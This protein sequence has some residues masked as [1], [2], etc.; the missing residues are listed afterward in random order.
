MLRMPQEFEVH[1]TSSLQSTDPI[2]FQS[3]SSIDGT[4]SYTFTKPGTYYYSTDLT[5]TVCSYC[6]V[7]GT[8]T[9]KPLEEL[10]TTLK[11]SVNGFPSLYNLNDS[12][13]SSVET[14]ESGSGKDE[15]CL[16]W[17]DA[18]INES[19][20][21]PPLFVYSEC[22]TP[23]VHSIMSENLTLLSEYTIYGASFGDESENTQVSFWGVSC[24]PSSVTY[25]SIT[26]K[27]N[28][29]SFPL[30][31]EPLPL[32]IHIDNLGYGLLLGD[33][34]YDRSISLNPVITN[35]Q[36]SQGSLLGGNVLTIHGRSFIEEN[37]QVHIGN[38]ECSVIEVFYEWITC[39]IP[40]LAQD[41]SVQNASLSVRVAYNSSAN[42]SA[43]CYN[44]ANCSYTYTIDYTP[45]VFSVTPTEVV[46]EES[47]IITISGALLEE[48]SKVMVGSRHECVNVTKLDDENVTCILYPIPAAE[49][50]LSVLVAEYG[51]AEVDDAVIV[52]RLQV[53]SVS[54]MQGSIRG[55]TIIT[56][57]GSG[58]S[59]VLTENRVRMGE[60]MCEVIGSSYST[61]NCSTPDFGANGT[62]SMAI[63]VTV[64]GTNASVSKRQV[65]DFE[66]DGFDFDFSLESTP[67]I[68]SISPSSG[69]EGDSVTISGSSFINT[70]SDIIVTIGDSECSVTSSTETSITCT[71]GQNF[72]GAFPVK[73]T[74][75]GKG[76]A[77]GTVTF[78]YTLRVSGI[79]PTEGSFAGQNTLTVNGV[80][81]RPTSS[82]VTICDKQCTPS[83]TPPSLTSLSCI[84][85]SFAEI[86]SNDTNISS[87]N[88]TVVVSSMN[89]NV[90]LENAYTLKQELTSFVTSIND[91]RGGTA[92]GTIIKLGG[93]GF[94]GSPN[95]TVAG[96]KCTVIEYDDDEIICMTGAIG[97][98]LVAE[99]M[100]H[101][102]GKGYAIVSN[103]VYFYYVDL[104]SS[105]FTWGGERLPVEGDFVIVGAGQ[106]LVLD[107][108]TPILKILLIQ[109]GELIFDD[110]SSENGIQLHSELILITDGGSLKIGT[111]SHPYMNKAEIVMY[112]NVLSTELPLFGAK[113]LAVRNGTVDFHG[114]PITNTWTR[115]S[116]TAEPGVSTILVQDDV[117]DWEVDGKIVIASTS[118]SQ[119]ENEELTI[120]SIGPDG[121]TIHLK[122]PL[123][124][125][126]IFYEQTI[127]GRFIQTSAE[128]GY[129]TRNVVFRGNRNEE[130]DVEYEACE[131]EFDPG[132][133]AVQ[134][135]FNGRFGA[136]TVGDQFGGQLMLHKGPR[137]KVVGR[138]EYTEFTHVGQA[139]R[140]G[141]YPIHFHL[142]GDVSDSYV[143]GNAIHHTFN[144]AVTIHAVDYLLV[145]KN[146]AFDI[147]GH[148][149]FLE[150]GIEQGNIIQDNLGVFV[151]A[152]SS[153]L[154]VDI[155]PATFWVVN[156]NNTLRRN[157]AAGGSH[158]G[159]W[160]R[161]PANPTGPSFTTAVEPLHLPL[162]EFSDNTAHSFGWYGIWIFP[163]Y[164]PGGAHT[165]NERTPAVFKNFLS[166]RNVRGVEFSEVGAVQLVNSTMLDNEI[167]G[168]EYTTVTAAWGKQGALIEDT[169]IVAHS[170]LRD[171]DDKR[172]RGGG[173][174]CTGS[175]IKTPH[176]YYLTVSNVTF[177][178]FN[179]SNCF[180]LQACSHCR[181]QQGGFETRFENLTFTNSPNIATWKWEHEQVFR[182]MDGTLTGTVGGALLPWMNAL[183]QDSCQLHAAGSSGSVAGAI[184]DAS[185]Q[186]NRFAL[187]NPSP[188]SL[189]F[190]QLNATNIH[191]TVT[192]D[193]VLKRLTLGPGY[194][195]ILPNKLEYTLEWSEGERFTNISYSSLYSGVTGDDYLFIR[196][197]FPRDVDMIN[198]NGRTKNASIDK[199][200]P[201]VSTTGDWFSNSNDTSVTYFVGGTSNCPTNVPVQFTTYRCFYEDCIPPPPPEPSTPPPDGRPNVTYMWS[202]P[203]IWPNGVVPTINDTDITINSSFYVLVDE[204]DIIPRIR[205]L[206]IYGS[207]EILD[208]VDRVIQAELIIIDEFGQLIAGS[209]DEQYQHQLDFVLNGNLASPI[210]RL[211]NGGPVLGAKAIGVF[212]RLSLHAQE[213]EQTWTFLSSTALAG[214][215]EINVESPVDWR[216]GETIVIS[217]TSF[218]AN[219]AEEARVSSVSNDG[220]TITLDRPLA[221][222]HLGGQHNTDSCTVTISAEVGLL[223]RNIRVLGTLPDSTDSTADSEAYGCRVLVSTYISN[224][225]IQYAGSAQLSGVEFKG[226]GQ[227]GFVESFDPRYSLAFL[228]IGTVTGNSSYVTNCSVHDGYNVGIGVYG[229]NGISLMNNV[230]HNTVGTSIDVRG[231]GHSV[232][233]NLAVVAQFPGTYRG[234]DEPFNFEWTANYELTGA[235]D[236][237]L[238]GNSAAGGAR[239]G[240]HTNGENCLVEGFMPQWMNNIAH[241]TLMGI[242]LPY[243][244]GHVSGTTRG[245]SAL[246][247]FHI[248]SAYHY[249]I[250]SFSR[251]GIQISDCTLV[252]NYAAVFTAVIGPPALSHAISE[253]TVTISD[254][255]II[256]SIHNGDSVANCTAYSHKPVIAYH[257]RSHS[258]I[259]TL[260][261]GH[262]GIILT[263]FT[264][265]SGGFPK[266]PW[267]ALHNYPAIS[268]H[269]TLRN[270]TF[271]KFGMHCGSRREVAL[272]THPGSEDC[273][274]PVELHNTELIDVDPESKF[275]NHNPNLGSINPS[276]CVDMDC[277]GLKK[278]LIRD[279]DGSFIGSQNG[280]NT[281]TSNSALEWDGN[282]RRGLGD[283]RIPRTMLAEPDGGMIDPD[284]LYPNKGIYRGNNEC[285]FNSNWNSY[286]CTGID[287][288]MMVVESLDADTEVRRLSPIGI[289]AAGY[290]DLVNGPQDN[291]WCG[292]YTCQERISTFYTIVATG[293]EY[294]IGLASTNPQDMRLM[295]LNAESTQ[296]VLIGLFYN[297]PQRLDI[298]VDTRFIAPTNGYFDD[299]GNLRYSRGSTSMF[300]P[301]LSNS[302]GANFYDRTYKKLYFVIEGSKPITIMTQSVIQL[303]IDLPAVT[304]DEF[305]ETN[306]IQNLALLLNIPQNRIRIVNVVS[307]SSR[308]RQAS[309]TRVEIEIGSPPANET[310]QVNRTQTTGGNGTYYYN[311]TQTVATDEQFKELSEAATRTAEI[312]QTGALSDSI[313]V[314]ILSASLTP[315]EPEVVDPTGGV[316]ATEDTGGPQPGDPGTENRT[317]YSEQ[318]AQQ[319]EAVQNST[320]PISL[321]IPTALSSV[322]ISSTGIEGL[323][324]S[325]PIIIAMHDGNGDVVV[326]LGVGVAWR[327][328]VS[329][330][331]GPNGAF[332][333]NNSVDMENGRATFS[334]LMFSHAGSY[335]LRFSVSYPTDADFTLDAS[336]R[337]E[338]STRQLYIQIETQPPTEANTTF[339]LY[340][341]ARI[342]IRDRSNDQLALNLGW[343]ERE[344]SAVATVIES[345]TGRQYGSSHKSEIV[346]GYSMFTDIS[347]DKEGIYVLRFTL[348]TDPQSTEAELPVI[349]DSVEIDV[350][351][352]PFT[353]FEIV[354]NE[355]FE[356]VIGN[357]VE[358]FKEAF[359]RH[360]TQ[361][362]Q[363]ITIYNI[364][365]VS[366]SIIVSFFATT[367]NPDTLAEF[368]SAVTM[369]GLLDSFTYNGMTLNLTSAIQDPN[370]PIIYPTEPP[371]KDAK[372]FAVVIVSIAVGSAILLAMCV[373]TFGLFCYYG[374]RKV[375]KQNR[376][377]V[378]PIE[379]D[380]EQYHMST[381]YRNSPIFD[382]DGDYP[383][384]HI[385]K[386]DNNQLSL[387]KDVSQPASRSSTMESLDKAEKSYHEKAMHMSSKEIKVG[388]QVTVFDNPQMT[389]GDYEDKMSLDELIQLSSLNNNNNNSTMLSPPPVYSECHPNSVTGSEVSIPPSYRSSPVSNTYPLL[390][391]EP[392]HTVQAMPLGVA[393]N[394]LPPI[395]TPPK[396]NANLGT[397]LT[398]ETIH[399]LKVTTFN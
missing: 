214:A 82:F 319:Q 191:G 175:G 381:V 350:K 351:Q 45:M 166:W 37:L 307:E 154:N 170:E 259:Q 268:G 366:G 47:A 110:V 296:K 172:V 385:V 285:T 344:W 370:Y 7:A 20:T 96:I 180:A 48:D 143:R 65:E 334:D 13:L 103:D 145:E 185:V 210:Y 288:L 208:K 278:I 173:A 294:S 360:L 59:D 39:Q 1:Q 98:T 315:P 117:S 378:K 17:A 84:V 383:L 29:T 272:M 227:E 266:F 299:E 192:L 194:M 169:L 204:D 395:R 200:D 260:T 283:Y 51:Y 218:E 375:S 343:R 252:N 221:N 233:N 253:K 35:I 109:G 295:I 384:F 205:R 106:T 69:Q 165:C 207:L 58:F 293:L 9:V 316:R 322:A 105:I 146:V 330:I 245:C 130:W 331:S 64:A 255:R 362:H 256:S 349:V 10:V 129:L 352:L 18:A 81:F 168:V 6:T 337:I 238:Y 14:F 19:L 161:L 237:T 54:P 24:D 311:T 118:Y 380:Y 160:Y 12:S 289:G 203:S 323:T 43:V 342:S 189:T 186:F 270:V 123:A 136:E 211:P 150:D 93:T 376:L 346:D 280:L 139:F 250:F 107:T 257:P 148:A 140:L 229:T 141:R 371:K 67:M 279:L 231:S 5:N 177:V 138:I 137:D 243:P 147:K 133:F 32:S 332:L 392:A 298:F 314:M 217:S 230:V 53:N 183:P 265:G 126:H 359:V 195:A 132:Q 28:Q 264:S 27:L 327:L 57:S 55:G 3:Q 124:Y 113:T 52:S 40:K 34:I 78:S 382:E 86:I 305:F 225:G 60:Q 199:P 389:Q 347:I 94:N 263:S 277:D 72:V 171:Y 77:N 212:G 308:K 340:P 49:Y 31:F 101:I 387:A 328:R 318:Q 108:I 310:Q 193:Y 361:E 179:E 74:I 269:T 309:S 317:T 251:A 302:H 181:T 240:Y 284:Q 300:L 15:K 287:H 209:P 282:P 372:Y 190:R 338:I 244:D 357:E 267:T 329:I 355:E 236:L 223:T 274:H 386:D 390:S 224:A 119:R 358:Q 388:E 116:A 249:G 99:V 121:K 219:E 25:K 83:N 228:N 112:G 286:H 4:F 41:V 290:I 87:K 187:T 276:D 22:Y 115:L 167:A 297:S 100:V 46:G 156:P 397:K 262:V 241:S 354:F 201:E 333:T 377:K 88:C 348:E 70:P 182:D 95:V 234:R 374:T 79:D 258:G 393:Q 367:S 335:R 198:V 30:P 163:S 273:Q 164:H 356:E 76:R 248:Y 353:R 135:C 63:S 114:K 131:E 239:A 391:L 196:H 26:C 321:S 75:A 215:T 394:E 111:E 42:K 206:T 16:S 61:I 127:E 68:T 235:T 220:L 102:S 242:H 36:P 261:S 44:M 379:N 85:P 398:D 213:R 122:E 152:S 62:V 92:G 303:G 226:C 291:G 301:T 306:L 71:L 396:T 23:I 11:V 90:T 188:S 365:V 104:W 73:A 80:G 159:F 128:V 21:N 336:T 33:D 174:I 178:N 324:L 281:L 399:G 50:S 153:L 162:A 247:N 339:G 56:I 325:Q 216:V 363:S 275:F 222:T 184:C 89:T 197:D 134:T 155:T 38:S 125:R 2:G 151:K 368:S 313:G 373:L 312:I 142:N 8:I 369:G 292:G 158:F 149:Y 341:Y 176:T 202:D 320:E 364:T 91:T 304:V 345:S 271:C 97:R 326:N 66:A 246:H 157:A 144:R 254:T 232:V 120:S